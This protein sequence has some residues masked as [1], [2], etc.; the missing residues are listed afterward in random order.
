MSLIS[1]SMNHSVKFTFPTFN[2]DGKQ[3]TSW[4]NSITNYFVNKEHCFEIITRLNE[5]RKLPDYIIEG[6][7]KPSPSSSSTK[8]MKSAENKAQDN[9]ITISTSSG[10]SPKFPRWQDFAAENVYGQASRQIYST[11]SQLVGEVVNQVLFTQNVSIGDGAAAWFTLL[12]EYEKINSA[13]KRELCSE[14]FNVKYSSFT[15]E[16]DPLSAYHYRIA[17]LFHDLSQLKFSMDD[18]HLTI[19]LHG[20]PSEFNQIVTVINSKDGMDLQEAV[21]QCKIFKESNKSSI[22]PPTALFTHNKQNK[23]KNK[24]HRNNNNHHQQKQQGRFPVP[25]SQAQSGG[26]Y[27][28]PCVFCSKKGIHKF[29]HLSVE[30]RSRDMNAKICLVCGAPSHQSY[31]CPAMAQFKR[32]Q[33]RN[34]QNQDQSYSSHRNRS[35]D[36]YHQNRRTN[37]GYQV[38]HAHVNH[39]PSPKFTSSP[40]MSDFVQVPRQQYDSMLAA[41]Q[42]QAQQPDFVQVPRDQYESM[43]AAQS[44]QS[45]SDP[46]QIHSYPYYQS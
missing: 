13:S 38:N 27:H 34:H 42:H 8:S 19:F 16:K 7:A 4:K 26:K 32:S 24:K 12:N 5:Y 35:Q 22:S 28:F 41:Q 29:D 39:A 17:K 30:C 46:S 40:A 31:N 10:D 25:S 37:Q 23:S 2:G 21:N 45:N 1:K 20:L 33:N 18:L 14:L 36:Y 3:W 11:I 15:S 9:L 43:I 6:R 44:P